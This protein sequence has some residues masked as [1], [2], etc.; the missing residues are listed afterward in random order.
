MPSDVAL[1]SAIMPTR[2]R[3]QWAADAVRMFQEQTWP[4]KE[5]VVIDDQMDRS[6]P[7]GLS[8]PGIQYHLAPRVTIGEKRNLAVSRSLGVIIMHWDSDDIYRADRMEHQVNLLLAC[9][10]DLTG[11]YEMEFVDADSGARYM[12]HASPG[13]AIGVSQ[14]YWRDTW[15]KMRF[16]SVNEGED[17]NFLNG[18]A[19]FCVPADGR[20]IARIHNDN[21]SDKRIRIPENPAQW[22]RIA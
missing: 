10:A 2:G 14:C 4:H 9:G 11:Y 17:S 15:E 20:I 18:R 12:Y 1:T 5:L 3:H 7:N 8:G 13:Y 16:D 21:T 19:V 6:F 22:Q